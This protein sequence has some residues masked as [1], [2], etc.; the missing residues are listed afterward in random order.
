MR[1]KNVS[2]FERS[3]YYDSGVKDYT[4]VY[5]T[6]REKDENL[7]TDP[8]LMEQIRKDMS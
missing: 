5:K 6:Q 3:G 7:F 8:K 4:S 2:Q 1:S